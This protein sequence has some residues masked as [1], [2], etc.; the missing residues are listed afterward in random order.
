MV[1]LLCVCSSESL[2]EEAAALSPVIFDAIESVL[3]SAL[4]ASDQK[5]DAAVIIAETISND[6]AALVLK[7]LKPN[8]PITFRAPVTEGSEEELKG[9]L[10]LLGYVNVE[11]AGP[12]QSG[13]GARVVQATAQASQWQQGSAFSISLKRKQ[14]SPEPKKQVLVNTDADD[15]V[16]EAELLDETDLVKPQVSQK[17]GC[18]PTRK[19]CKN[20]SCGRAEQEAGV[21]ITDTDSAIAQP[22]AVTPS[23]CGNCALG[24]AFRCA[25][26]PF[27]GAPAFKKGEEGKVLLDLNRLAA[28]V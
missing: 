21:Q 2:F 25:G 7:Q 9:A 3:V 11:I 22:A 20:C 19:A 15:F 14:P 24:D 4:G 23:S 13:L 10:V 27:L 26:C 28:D 5:F 6:T 16:D 17:K 18:P 8:S 1:K 12:V